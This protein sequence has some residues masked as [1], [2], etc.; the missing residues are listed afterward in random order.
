M[1]LKKELENIK[2]EDWI[3]DDLLDLY[4]IIQNKI[5]QQLQFIM[6]SDYEEKNN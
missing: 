5:D 4:N 2:T 6:M 1:D 3:I